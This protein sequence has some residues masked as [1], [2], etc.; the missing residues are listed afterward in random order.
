MQIIKVASVE[1]KPQKKDPTKFF[2]IL[3]DEAGAEFSTFDPLLLQAK[4][5]DIVEC[6]VEINGQF[7][8]LVKGFKIIPAVQPSP[9]APP[10]PGQPPVQQVVKSYGKTD[11]Q[12]A[13]E[14][15]SI[16]RQ[17]SL[18]L[19]IEFWKC[20]EEV[21]ECS[22]DDILKV[23][24][25]FYQWISTG[26]KGIE[27][28]QV[29]STPTPKVVSATATKP[30]PTSEKM[31]EDLKSEGTKLPE[32]KTADE[33]FVFACSKPRMDAIGLKPWTWSKIQ[34]TLGIKMPADLKDL[35]AASKVLFARE[36]L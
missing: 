32:F 10:A 31:Y 22:T 24:D 12:L 9:P 4:R 1:K 19:A 13:I 29:V 33:M 2:Y 6:E 34:E 11:E 21:R 26:K 18:K 36:A 14:R 35:P 23:A 30:E 3:K 20:P 27:S 5:G 15:R 17:S 28:K 16:E 7:A 25:L 8:N